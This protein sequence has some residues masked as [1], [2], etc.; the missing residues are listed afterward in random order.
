MSYADLLIGLLM[1]ALVSVAAYSLLAHSGDQPDRQL[2]R[3]K[4]GEL[5]AIGDHQRSSGQ[6]SG[7]GAQ[8]SAPLQLAAGHYRID[9]QF[10]APTRV[11]LIDANGDETLFIKSGN[12]AEGFEIAE[13][14]RYRL[15]IE[16]NDDNAEWR[17]A[18]RQL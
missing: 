16:P 2:W 12:G 17:I 18:Y 15:L 9:Y 5:I 13:T 10:D 1:I 4:K 6:V 3:D 7:R 14:A 8:T 11:A